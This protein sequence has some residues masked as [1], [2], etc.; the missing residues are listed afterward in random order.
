MA[1][2]KEDVQHIANL[3]RLEL[4]DEGLAKFQKELSSILEYI[5]QLAAVKTEDVEPVFQ[6]TG[7]KNVFREDAIDEKQGLSAEEALKN[8]PEQEKGY[9]KVKPVL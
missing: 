2:R 7:L 6:T 4:G 8:A 3:A 5:S 9:F 1:I